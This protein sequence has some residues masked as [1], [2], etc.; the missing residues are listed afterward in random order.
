MIAINGVA[1]EQP[2]ERKDSQEATPGKKRDTDEAKPS[3]GSKDDADQHG[4]KNA[5][6]EV[7]DSPNQSQKPSE[8]KKQEADSAKKGESESAKKNGNQNPGGEKGQGKTNGDGN[9]QGGQQT[10]QA[11][12]SGRQEGQRG[13]GGST[14]TGSRRC[15]GGRSER[16]R[17]RRQEQSATP[18]LSLTRRNGGSGVYAPQPLKTSCEMRKSA[19]KSARLL[20]ELVGRSARRTYQGVDVDVMRLLIALEVGDNPLPALEAPRKRPRLRVLITPDSS[21]STQAWSGV[22]S[23]WALHLAQM[24]DVDVIHF[25]N[26]NGRFVDGWQHDLPAEDVQR[27]LGR[28]DIVVYLGDSDGYELCHRYASQGATVV[29]LDCYSANVA[30]PRLKE[31][32]DKPSGGSVRWVDRVSAKE[33]DTWHKALEL[34]LKR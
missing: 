1:V 23:A 13:S 10:S 9:G 16:T 3:A 19:E 5:A 21:G 2:E 31:A 15:R 24:P 32:C 14:N 28:A 18:V 4:G 20:S 7:K 34:V 25:P 27:L 8:Q 17:K 11:G 29:A 12:Q 26:F 33:P 22:S 6:E 30:N